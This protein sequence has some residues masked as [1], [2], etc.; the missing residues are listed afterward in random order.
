MHP[1]LA[2]LE[3]REGPT[4]PTES[5]LWDKYI[6]AHVGNEA[7]AFARILVRDIPASPLS[8]VAGLQALVPEDA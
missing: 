2:V 8:S 3:S 1:L 5:M 4:T 6:N 7:G